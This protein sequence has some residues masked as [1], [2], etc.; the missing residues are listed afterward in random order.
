MSKVAVIVFVILGFIFLATSLD[1][2]SFVLASTASIGEED[3][4]E[5]A[6]WHTIIWGCIMAIIAIAL[7]L[8]GGLNVVQSSTVIV[9]V[10]VLLI[11]SLLI[12]SIL[13]WLR[14]DHGLEGEK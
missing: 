11:Y 12:I 2:A 7:L 6:T 9:A 13:R 3:G 8:I 10:P 1:S 4:E 5:P 14:Q